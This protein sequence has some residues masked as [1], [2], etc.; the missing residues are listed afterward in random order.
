M[1][2]QKNRELIRIVIHLVEM[3]DS[4]AEIV[5]YLLNYNNDLGELPI[6]V[7]SKNFTP[8]L[9][10]YLEEQKKGKYI[11]ANHRKAFKK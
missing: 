9:L 6:D 2:T 10:K 4:P 8:I 7:L 3:F 1:M 11:N 5:D